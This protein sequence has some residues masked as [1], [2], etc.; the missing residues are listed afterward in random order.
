LE[1]LKILLES[2]NNLAL[3]KK[4]YKDINNFREYINGTFIKISNIFGST[5]CPGIDKEW[6]HINNYKEYLKKKVD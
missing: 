2:T 3:Y 5:T 6:F 4:L 1:K